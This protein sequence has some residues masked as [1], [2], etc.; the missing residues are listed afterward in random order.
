MGREIPRNRQESRRN[1]APEPFYG[2]REEGRQGYQRR[3]APYQ[4]G[5]SYR[6]MPNFQQE[7]DSYFAQYERNTG[8]GGPFRGRD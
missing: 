7:R 5:S 6:Y 3:G 1:Q 8:H 4:V 2:M